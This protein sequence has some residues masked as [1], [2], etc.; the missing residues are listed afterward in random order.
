MGYLA[1]SFELRGLDPQRAEAAC[2][3]LGAVAITF[4]DGGDDAVLE[5]APGELRLWP[6]TRLQA[7]FTGGAGRTALRQALARKLCLASGRI[8]AER[9]AERAW[10]REWRRDFHATRFGRRL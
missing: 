6:A 9:L 10:E 2:L 8:F 4:S 7:L 5:P 3:E 1:L